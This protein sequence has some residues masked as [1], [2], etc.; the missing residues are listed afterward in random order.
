MWFGM[1]WY[2][3]TNVNIANRANEFDALDN[4]TLNTFS[5]RVKIL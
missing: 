5:A 1:K 3:M 4:L 2:D